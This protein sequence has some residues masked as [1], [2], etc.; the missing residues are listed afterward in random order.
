MGSIGSKCNIVSLFREAKYGCL[1]SL[2]NKAVI[3][4]WF[5]ML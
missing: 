3:A 2:V 1:Q 4:P 5:D